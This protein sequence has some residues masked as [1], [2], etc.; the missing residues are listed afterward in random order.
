MVRP[1]F[2]GILE[3]LRDLFPAKRIKCLQIVYHS[4]K[5]RTPWYLFNLRPGL[6]EFMYH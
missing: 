1:S 4:L 2:F 6:G 5:I 3:N